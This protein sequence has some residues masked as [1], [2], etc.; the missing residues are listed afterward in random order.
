MGQTAVFPIKKL[1]SP[2]APARDESNPP[3][4][5]HPFWPFP[6]RF[7][8]PALLF[9]QGAKLFS[10]RTASTCRR[11]SFARENAIP[12]CRI[13]YAINSILTKKMPVVKHQAILLKK[14]RRLFAPL[15]KAI[16]GFR[17][18]PFHS[19]EYRATP[20]PG[21]EGQRGQTA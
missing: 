4:W 2:A 13:R 1:P 16:T 15:F 20:C 3:P 17:P 18:G 21:C 8:F 12:F 11:L 9:C 5:F 7:V 6:A 19:P 10:H 14:E